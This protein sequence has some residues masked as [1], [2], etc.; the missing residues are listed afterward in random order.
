MI[1]SSGLSE[2]G[3][4][5]S[6][7]VIFSY[8]DLSESLY[9][10]GFRFVKWGEVSNFGKDTTIL[11]WGVLIKSHSQ[12]VSKSVYR[13]VRNVIIRIERSLAI[14]VKR[15]VCGMSFDM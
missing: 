8:I 5:G 13:L 9:A 14:F 12:W 6:V 1:K 2:F 7:F 11:I 10:L 15:R 3:G 4:S